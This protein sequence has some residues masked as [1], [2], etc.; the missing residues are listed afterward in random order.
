MA[1]RDLPF[2]VGCNPIIL[3]VVSVPYDSLKPKPTEM[4]LIATEGDRYLSNKATLGE[5][6][7]FCTNIHDDELKTL[8]QECIEP[9]T[10]WLLLFQHELYIRAFNILNSFEPIKT[11]EDE[12]NYSRKLK[13]LL[14][15]HQVSHTSD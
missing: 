15:D 8:E 2:I 7:A 9:Y 1:F 14:E 12:V 3:G 5:L 11:R 13:E 6:V 10:L 4:V